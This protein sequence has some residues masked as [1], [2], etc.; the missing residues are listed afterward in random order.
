MD[1]IN[2]V[3]H[4][5]RELD[6]LVEP[7]R[8]WLFG[9]QEPMETILAALLCGGHVLL[10]GPP[11]TAKTMMIK[12]MAQRFDAPFKRIQFT[13][14]LM[15]ADIIGT[16]VFNQKESTF[17]FHPG[18]LFC[19]FLLADEINRAP[20]KTQS[21]L[22]EAMQELQVT[23]EGERYPLPPTFTVFATQNPLEHEGTYPLPE[24]QLDRFLFKILLSYPPRQ[25]ERHMLQTHHM[26]VTGGTEISVSP[27]LDEKAL[28]AL[29]EQV[30]AVTVEDS[31]FEYVLDLVAQ[32]RSH[33]SIAI[34][35]SPRAAVLWIKAS[36]AF[37]F[38]DNRA[39]VIPDDVKRAGKPLLRHRLI[40]F[41]QA[42][43]EGNTVDQV[44][45]AMFLAVQPPR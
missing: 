43:L 12:L 23:V 15:P 31:I 45:D 20:A 27:M 32:S 29:R 35:A 34:G 14:D 40:L 44:I 1:E 2:P 11:G 37:A 18:P 3:S 26:Q 16:N 39:Y 25:A 8:Q 6:E 28:L 4:G 41:P 33:P 17:R 42:E 10:E 9:L 7:I 13:P 38:M 36:K 21:A 5:R 24:A 19:S 30:N 22:L